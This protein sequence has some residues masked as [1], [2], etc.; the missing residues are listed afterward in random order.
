MTEPRC[1]HDF[2]TR[3][4]ALC[5]DPKPKP[6]FN[7]SKGLN[8][9]PDA[10]VVEAQFLSRCP[11]CDETIHEGDTIYLLADED[12]WVCGECAK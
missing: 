4:C 2:S 8:R 7:G 5:N 12:M 11:Q 1:I 3:M 6:K 10:L 9:K